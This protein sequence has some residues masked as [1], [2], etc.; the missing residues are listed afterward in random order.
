MK[1]KDLKT[2]LAVVPARVDKKLRE[3]AAKERRSR[4][5]QLNRILEERYGFAPSEP[6]REASAA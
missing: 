5:A 1:P 4:Q 3:E 6:E 2:F